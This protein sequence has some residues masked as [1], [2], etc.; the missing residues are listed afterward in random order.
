MAASEAPSQ[1]AD[2]VLLQTFRTGHAVRELMEHAVAGT[3]VSADEWAVLSAVGLF[4]S[5]APTRL[6]TVL[7]VPPTSISR[8]VARL[9][10]NDLVVRVPNEADRRSYLLE[11]T[12]EGQRA[13]DAIAPRFRALVTGLEEHAD[14][15]AIESALIQ[16]E[17][18]AKA[19]D[20][21]R[22]AANR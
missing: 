6:A 5:V 12:D 17:Q 3:G 11:L 16:L 18:A 10:S 2:N 8:Y 21:D 9:A 20:V 4:R 14:V 15:R 19:L 22:S 1:R 13:V 7:R